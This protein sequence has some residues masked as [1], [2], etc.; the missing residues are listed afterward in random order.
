M[1]TYDYST[2]AIGRDFSFVRHG[3]TCRL[4]NVESSVWGYGCT[5]YCQ[6][7]K[8]CAVGWEVHDVEDTSY[9]IC[10]HPSSVDSEGCDGVRYL[11]FDRLESEAL[12]AL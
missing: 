11:Y 5:H 1:M 2:G 7:N 4:L 8:G 9:V 10:S 12:S 6:F 3:E